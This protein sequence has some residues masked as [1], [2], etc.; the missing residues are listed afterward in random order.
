MSRTWSDLLVEDHNIIERV[1]DA[2]SRGLADD[3][4][5]SPQLLESFKV[6]AVEYLDGCHN[7]KEERHL[8]PRLEA[9]G[10]PLS[11][12][13][14]AVMLAE[15]AQS[16]L[17]LGE[18]CGHIE[19]YCQG[20]RG[21]LSEVHR[22]FGQYATLLKGHFWKETDILYPMGRRLFSESEHSEVVVGIEATEAEL[23]PTTHAKYYALA[24]RICSMGNLEDLS[25]GLPPQVLSAM[26]NALPI[27]LSFVDAEET[28][29]Y[30]SHEH[31]DK[32]FPRTR[33]AI[34]TKVQNCHPP[35]SLH[36]VNQILADFRTGKRTV[37]EFWI[38]LGPRKIHIRYFPL[39]DSWG[40]Y[41]GC[42]ETVQDVTSIQQ[43]SG[44]KRLLDNE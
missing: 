36:M 24:Q 6:F 23:G 9:A 13:P 22:L 8:F 30:F 38:D 37:A 34:G 31:H 21:A 3:S 19:L 32:I 28:V 10:L 20:D 29:R 4:G 1:F 14:L 42:L 12:G 26:L 2:V 27:E 44:Q 18:L 33:G 15:H 35:K 39:R 17:L 41:L 11:S 16:Q 5:P 40:T 25:S 43:L 7:Q